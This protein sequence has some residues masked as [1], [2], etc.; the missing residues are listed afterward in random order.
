MEAPVKK[1]NFIWDFID[2]DLETGRYQQICTRFPP[3]PNGYLHIGHCKAIAAD[4]LTA[5]RYGGKCNLRFDDTNPEKEETEFVDGIMADIR[6]LGFRLE[7]RAVFR[8][9]V[10][11][12]VLRYRRGLDQ[13]RPGLRG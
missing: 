9:R 2:E 5:E 12:G 6:W 11:S 13:A 4:F 7:R 3:E 1:T 10:L 8:K